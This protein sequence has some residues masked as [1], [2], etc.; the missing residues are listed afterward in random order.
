M[1][2]KPKVGDA[3]YICATHLKRLFWTDGKESVGAMAFWEDMQRY[4]YLPRMRDREAL[5]Q[6]I[7]KGT[8]TKDFFGT[9]YGTDRRNI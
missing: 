2:K 5:E 4:L 3:V 6:A 7:V 8:A 9:A 1:V